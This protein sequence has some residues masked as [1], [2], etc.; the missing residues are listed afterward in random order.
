MNLLVS[1]DEELISLFQSG[2]NEAFAI[3]LHRYADQ[4]KYSIRQI[5]TILFSALTHIAT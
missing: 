3:L 4:I 2:N 1:S 5:V